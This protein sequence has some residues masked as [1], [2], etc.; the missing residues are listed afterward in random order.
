MDEIFKKVI[1]DTIIKYKEIIFGLDSYIGT[2]CLNQ[3]RK[4]QKW[5]SPHLGNS[6]K[7]EYT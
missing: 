6:Q 1:K 2:E 5:F 7:A 3:L 4:C